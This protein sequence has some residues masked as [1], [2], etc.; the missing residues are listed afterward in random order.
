MPTLLASKFRG[1]SSCTRRTWRG[2]I[3]ALVHQ[4]HTNCA[5]LGALSQQSRRF[6]QGNA[7]LSKHLLLNRTGV[8]CATEAT[9]FASRTFQTLNWGKGSLYTDACEAKHTSKQFT[10][11]MPRMKLK[12]TNNAMHGTVLH[13]TCRCWVY[14]LC[15]CHLVTDSYSG[16][17]VASLTLV[18]ASCVHDFCWEKSH[19]LV[20]CWE[21][22]KQYLGKC[23]SNDLL[24][25]CALLA[26]KSSS[27]RKWLIPTQC[28]EVRETNGGW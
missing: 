2:W 15:Y 9:F 23:G 7:I 18:S 10:L 11:A 21:R 4:R 5:S 17:I 26:M 20:L 22:S 19:T 28:P 1:S 25:L 13:C 27:V 14:N 6:R 8:T 16:S 3:S 12:T 24:F